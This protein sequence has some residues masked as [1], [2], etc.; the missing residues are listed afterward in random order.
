[1]INSDHTDQ[2]AGVVMQVQFRHVAGHVEAYDFAGNFL[3]S[4]DTMPEAYAIAEEV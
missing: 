1:M 3:F 4:A 2:K